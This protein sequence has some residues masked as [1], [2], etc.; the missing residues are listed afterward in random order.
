MEQDTTN[1]EIDIDECVNELKMLGV[2]LWQ[3]G[4]CEHCELIDCDTLMTLGEKLCKIGADI[5]T[6]VSKGISDGK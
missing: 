5:D 3:A 2:L 1:R 4:E 6:Y